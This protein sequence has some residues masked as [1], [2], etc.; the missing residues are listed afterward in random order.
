MQFLL[1][2]SEI[3]FDTFKMKVDHAQEFKDCLGLTEF[4]RKKAAKTRKRNNKKEKKRVAAQLVTTLASKNKQ[5]QELKAE[6]IKFNSHKSKKKADKP[7]TEEDDRSEQIFMSF[8]KDK[9]ELDEIRHQVFKFGLSGLGSAEREAAN[10]ALAIKLGAIPPKNKCIPLQELHE[11]R[12]Q[13][14]EEKRLKEEED[15]NKWVNNP[16]SRKSNPRKGKQGGMTGLGSGTK[17]GK[18]D[19]GTLKISNFELK[20]A[21]RKM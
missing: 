21:K 3:C 18:F 9:L 6:V 17:L 13:E 1:F 5:S 16:K 2:F 7:E 10:V 8:N 12:K 11:K 19:G 20:R 15:R 14:K 4:E